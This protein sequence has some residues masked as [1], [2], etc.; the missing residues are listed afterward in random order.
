MRFRTRLLVA[1]CVSPLA[2]LAQPPH[3]SPP[4]YRSA[5]DDYRRL[6]D[7]KVDWKEANDNV[8]RIGGWRTY[9]RESQRTDTPADTSTDRRQAE[10]AT[11]PATK[12]SMPA[13]PGGH[14]GH[15]R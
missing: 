1:L 14:G 8:A 9:L 3:V 2:A 6:T 11:P 15:K 10:P 4:T 13:S 5:F 12:P 7:D